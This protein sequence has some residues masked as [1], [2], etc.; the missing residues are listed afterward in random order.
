MRSSIYRTGQRARCLTDRVKKKF[1]EAGYS[2]IL[3]GIAEALGMLRSSMR[4][5]A[6]R[7]LV[8][9][10]FKIQVSV[11]VSRLR[12][13]SLIFKPAN[14][15]QSFA[16]WVCLAIK[17]QCSSH[18]SLHSGSLICYRSSVAIYSAVSYLSRR[19]GEAP[20]SQSRC[21]VSS[22]RTGTLLSFRFAAD[23]AKLEH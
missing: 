4:K 2:W 10:M 17:I 23:V 14:G 1:E 9:R 16:Y 12:G 3:N 21:C 11:R 5:A 6:R 7:G 22:C 15:W 20:Q 8:R 19:P 18:A 13:S